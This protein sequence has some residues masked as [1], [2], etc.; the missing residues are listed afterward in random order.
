MDPRLHGRQA[1][2]E[3]LGDL[4]IRQPL[5]VVED[6][7]RPVV[8]RQAVDGFAEPLTR[9][10][11]ERGSSV[12]CDQSCPGSTRW[13]SPSKAGSGPPGHLVLAPPVRSF[14]YA[15]LAVIRR[16]SSQGRRP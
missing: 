14:S 2:P 15:A 1:D 10:G 8:R 4:W 7:G 9:L 13:P 6:E 11:P 5:H 3:H 12:C 16:S